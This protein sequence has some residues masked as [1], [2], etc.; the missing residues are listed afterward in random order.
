MTNR[1]AQDFDNSLL[2]TIASALRKDGV[3]VLPRM[4]PE[5][6]VK[7]LHQDAQQN[8]GSLFRAA[9]VGRG[10]AQQHNHQ[11]RSDRTRWI[12]GQ[13][14]I[15]REWLEGM[16]VLQSF[17]NRHLFLGLYSF[18][19][20]FAH[21]MPGAH[22]ALHK[23]A[24]SGQANRV[25]S[26]VCYLNP[27]WQPEWGGELLLY[28]SSQQTPQTEAEAGDVLLRVLPEPGTIV[29]FLS[30]EFPHQV[31]PASHD[32]FSI[33]GWFRLNSS[34]SKHSDPQS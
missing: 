8:S 30:E 17:L 15:E 32:R 16:A 14:A 10:E 27:C 28:P 3:C 20:H 19:S 2:E 5:A 7:E 6:L 1:L 26:L 25:L 22:Y 13:T 23:D 9:G 4:M 12:D 33:A 31:L 29:L 11:V 34:T 21:Y 24:F 18:E